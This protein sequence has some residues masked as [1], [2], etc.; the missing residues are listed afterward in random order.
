MIEGFSSAISDDAACLAVLHDRELDAAT[1]A[2]L[3]QSNFPFGLGLA[4]PPTAADALRHMN[5][6]VLALP[7]EADAELLDDLAAGYAQIYLTGA[8][9]ASPCE[10]PWLDEDHIVCQTPMFEWRAIHRQAGL[11]V[12]NW[13]VRSDDHL[14]LQLAWIGHIAARCASAADWLK[15]ATILDE[16]TLRWLPDFAVRVEQRGHPFYA[17]L[18]AV[19]AEWVEALRNALALL[20]QT[21]RPSREAVEKRL[22]EAKKAVAAQAKPVAQAVQFVP[23]M[24]GPSW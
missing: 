15:V 9:Q 21:P 17:C 3:K 23:G 10:S 18:A 11:T 19:T 13:R 2:A 5:D 14:V 22:E 20:T 12:T 8:L 24:G 1:L 16:H 6:L 7:E 4:L